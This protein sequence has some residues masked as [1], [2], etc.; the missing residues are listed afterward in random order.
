MAT[1]FTC[2]IP[3]PKNH[4]KFFCEVTSNLKLKLLRILLLGTLR[5]LSNHS[6]LVGI[7][8]FCRKLGNGIT[9]WQR[10]YGNGMLWVFFL[11]DKN[12]VRGLNHYIF[13]LEVSTD[14][15][16]I[17]SIVKTVQRF[18]NLLHL[19]QM[20]LFLSVNGQRWSV[21]LFKI[22]IVHQGSVAEYVDELSKSVNT[23]FL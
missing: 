1:C 12:P 15:K 6:L 16:T 4:K 17:T 7:L 8:S 21:E 14:T 2:V 11:Q 22:Q 10:N 23:L 18:R 13:A 9:F 5:N 19:S 3:L 20:V